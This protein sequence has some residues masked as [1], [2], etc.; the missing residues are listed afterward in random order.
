[1]RWRGEVKDTTFGSCFSSGPNGSCDSQGCR[2]GHR[3]VNGKI[4]GEADDGL[5]RSR[6]ARDPLEP[7]GSV[8]VPCRYHSHGHCRP[9]A[10]C[11]FRHDVPDALA[12]SQHEVKPADGLTKETP[13]RSGDPTGGGDAPATPAVLEAFRQKRATAVRFNR[14][15]CGVKLEGSNHGPIR[16]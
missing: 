6:N 11:P 10:R 14:H 4:E 13:T 15:Q 3:T 8:Y 16:W 5:I 7:S 2:F 9:G 12:S 1:M